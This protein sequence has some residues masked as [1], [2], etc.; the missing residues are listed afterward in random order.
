MWLS[1]R[2]NCI[3][4]AL[5]LESNFWVFI[6]YR[7]VQHSSPA[8][9]WILPI[10]SEG[11]SSGPSSHVRQLTN[12]NSRKSSALFCHSWASVYTWHTLIW[13]DIY[14]C[15]KINYRKRERGFLIII[16]RKP[17]QLIS[18]GQNQIYDITREQF[19]P[20]YQFSIKWNC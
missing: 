18:H 17:W 12:I 10:S 14:T 4:L 3:R 1:C 11:T 8:G 15:I 2:T 16:M 5:N 6:S 7:D 20:I 9:K 19:C 13:V